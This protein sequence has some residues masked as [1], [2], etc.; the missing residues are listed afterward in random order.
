MKPTCPPCS[1]TTNVTAD[2]ATARARSRTP[3][4]RKGSSAE[5][6][7]SVGTVIRGGIA[8][9]PAQPDIFTST[10]GPGGR[11]A[12]CNAT[13]PA[14]CSPE[15][16]G[17]TSDDGTGTQVATVLR[18][19]VT[20]VRGALASTITVT[21]GTTVITASGNSASDRPGVDF[22]TFSLPATVNTGDLPIIITVSAA[23]SRDASTAPHI[24]INGGASPLPNPIDTTA[25]FVQQHY[26]DFLGREPDADGFAFWQNQVNQCVQDVQCL[27]VA[28]INVSASFFL[29]IENLETGFLVYRTYKAAYGNLNNG[30]APVPLTLAEFRV[31][32]AQIAKDVIVNQGNWQQQLAANKEAYFAD[33]VTR[34]RFINDY[35]TSL[36]ADAFV[37]RLYNRAGLA[38]GSGQNRA[39]ALS[40][41]MP[42]PADSAARA[43]ALRLVAEDPL[44]VQQEFNRAFV[45]MEYF[46]YLQRNPND[47]PD[48]NFDGYNFWLSKLNQFNGNYI[49]AEMVKAFLSSFEYRKRFGQ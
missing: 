23:S 46:G 26:R 33:F 34:Q 41:V 4:G 16:F 44:V 8:I 27:E 29:S 9:V 7:H 31:D 30:A 14:V 40:E 49:N 2:D 22:V 39:A 19:S 24:T 11:A 15:P 45:L 37:D 3:G 35:P 28:R 21:V 10:N 20:G 13:K 32:R 36:T 38:P 43:K 17:V 18:A 47:P 5:L 42:A 12:V 1:V 25:F 6:T 48:G